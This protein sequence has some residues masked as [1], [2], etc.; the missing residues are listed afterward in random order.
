ME[1]QDGSVRKKSKDAS[2]QQFLDAVGAVIRAK[3]YSGL[4]VNDLAAAAGLDKKL[5]YNYFG[6]TDEL[7]DTYIQSQD[8]WSK[9]G[10]DM[11]AAE[12][13]GGQ[14]FAKHILCQQFDF[15]AGNPELQKIVL[16]RLSEERDAL[17]KLTDT[18]EE[19]GEVLFKNIADPFFGDKAELFRATMAIMI[20]GLYYLNLYAS[21]NGSL[22]CG[23][24]IAS[25]QGKEK[26]KEAIAFM[27]DNS[28]AA[29]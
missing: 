20:S 29:R 4:K 10:R 21:V 27:I 22:F 1:N 13:D 23:I 26:I 25:E 19:N 28:Y 12:T 24:D 5:I 7:L 3:G 2:K 6:S 8:F 18:Q 17:R 16:W 11:V 9:V 14:Q 15:V